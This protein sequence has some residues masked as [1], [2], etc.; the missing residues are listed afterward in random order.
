[1]VPDMKSMIIP[2]P[3][4]PFRA[5]LLLMM[6]K[7]VTAASG[8]IPYGDMADTVLSVTAAGCFAAAMLQKSHSWKRL[9]GYAAILL[10]TLFSAWRTGSM[11]MFLTVLTCLA[12]YL[13]DFDGTIRFLLFWEG[14]YVALHVAASILLA[15]LGE[16][17]TTRVSG[18]PRFNFGFTHPNVFSILMMNLLGMW[19]WLNFERLDGKHLAVMLSVTLGFYAVTGT[20]SVLCAV[21]LLAGLVWLQNRS[22]L[23]RLGAA[24]CVPVV[25][26]VEYVLWRK[27]PGGNSLILKMDALLSGRISLG[28]YAYHNFGLTLLGQNLNE[29][30]IE[31]ENVWQL[32]SFTFDDVYS[33]LAVNHGLVW[34]ALIAVLF[35]RTA[36]KGSEKACIFIILWGLY[37]VT[38]MHGINPYLFFPILLAAMPAEDCHGS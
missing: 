34:L 22:G 30:T 31:W 28:S 10:L 33:Y 35:C 4:T 2:L 21:I 25:G 8:M 27:F 26:A 24:V 15:C 9:L 14:R 19:A 23:L 32:G 13:E 3:V 1:M 20:R 36:G 16:S 37:G 12:L 5:G 7:T 17:M 38:E 18:V 11:T 29:V 6:L